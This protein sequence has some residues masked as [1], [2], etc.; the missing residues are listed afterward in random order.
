MGQEPGQSGPR[1][2]GSQ[3]LGLQF[4]PNHATMAFRRADLPERFSETFLRRSRPQAVDS[5]SYY[6]VGHRRP[7]IL[8]NDLDRP[9]R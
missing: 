2:Y 8:C 3:G 9:C 1:P 7:P 4:S 5:T 6:P